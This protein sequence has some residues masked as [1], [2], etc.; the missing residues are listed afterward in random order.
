MPQLKSILYAAITAVAA[1][2][3]TAD[4]VGGRALRLRPETDLTSGCFDFPANNFDR[5]K[6][7]KGVYGQS[8]NLLLESGQPAIDFTL[9][10]Y[11]GGNAWN[12]REHLETGGEKPVVLIWGMYTCPA[13]QGMGDSPPIPPWDSCGY[14]D[15]YDLVEAYKDRATFVHLYGPEPHPVAPGTNF[16]KGM[17]VNSYWSTVPQPTSYQ[18]RLAMVDRVRDLFH[19]DEVVLPDYLPGN[20]YSELV[21]PVWCSYG[22]GARPATIIAPDGSILLQQLWLHTGRLAHQLDVLFSGDDAVDSEDTEDTDD[23][24]IPR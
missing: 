24:D 2:A 19:P 4:E 22:L 20:P 6:S 3:T 5:T 16:D 14:R 13:F 1:V 21:Q 8:P 15:E 9:Y 23:T 12:L 17:P 7:I 11:P 10:D 18:E